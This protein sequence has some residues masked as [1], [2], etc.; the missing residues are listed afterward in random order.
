MLVE[1]K[2]ELKKN[3]V[4]E[5]KKINCSTN[6]CQHGH[7]AICGILITSLRHRPY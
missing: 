7:L 5:L 1:E 3:K 2:K 4:S 6:L